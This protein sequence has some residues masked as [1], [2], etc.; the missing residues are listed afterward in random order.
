M[1]NKTFSDMYVFHTGL[2]DVIFFSYDHVRFFSNR[3]A[4]RAISILVFVFTS[5]LECP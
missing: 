2:Q 5:S 4:E 3:P 1:N